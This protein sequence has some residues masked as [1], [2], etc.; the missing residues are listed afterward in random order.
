[1]T[2]TRF[3][4]CWIRWRF[5]K[6]CFFCFFCVFLFFLFFL[7]FCLFCLSPGIGNLSDSTGWLAGLGWAGLLW[8]VYKDPPCL[9]RRLLL[10]QGE[11]AF[12]S[13]RKRLSLSQKE[14]VFVSG[15]DCFSA[16]QRDPP[17]QREAASVSERMSLF[18]S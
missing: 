10:S 12:H 11:V 9:R 6:L 14:I 3:L 13:L 16:F 2:K 17:C 15:R 18:A 5:F 8:L 4:K 7:V 1:M